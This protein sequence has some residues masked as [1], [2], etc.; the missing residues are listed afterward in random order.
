MAGGPVR[1]PYAGIDFIP[2]SEIYE[3]GYRWPLRV[4]KLVGEIFMPGHL[5]ETFKE[6]CDSDIRQKIEL[7]YSIHI[8][9]Y[10]NE[11]LTLVD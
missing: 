10:L 7:I 11:Y 9:A 6:L 4:L 8:L 5:Y 2:Q 3:F 1:Q